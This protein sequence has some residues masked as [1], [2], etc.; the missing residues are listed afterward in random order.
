[1]RGQYHVH[2]WGTDRQR[3]EQM[4]RQGKTNIPPPPQTSYAGGI[5]IILQQFKDT[6]DLKRSFQYLIQHWGQML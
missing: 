2:R 5:I 1:M 6:I 4:D 3:D